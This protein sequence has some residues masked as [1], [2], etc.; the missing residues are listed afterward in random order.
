[1]LPYGIGN[2]S[3]DGNSGNEFCFEYKTR[4]LSNEEFRSAENLPEFD[5]ENIWSYGATDNYQYPVLQIFERECKHEYGNWSV[6]KNLTCIEKGSKERTCT[7]CKTAKEVEDITM[8]PTAHSF[9]NYTYNNDAAVGKDGTE[10]AFCDYGC[11]TTDTKTKAGAALS[12]G[13]SSG[14]GIYIPPAQNQK[15]LQVMDIQRN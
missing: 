8:N 7:L 14:G 6:T 12:G 2:Y 11:G 15:F 3:Q 4:K 13:G 5:F 10:T 9:T 1:M